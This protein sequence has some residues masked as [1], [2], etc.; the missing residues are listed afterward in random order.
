[1]I[2]AS[3]SSAAV[4]LGFTSM[5]VGKSLMDTSRASLIARLELQLVLIV[6]T[7]F[8]NVKLTLVLSMS[9]QVSGEISGASPDHMMSPAGNVGKRGHPFAYVNHSRMYM[10]TILIC[11]YVPL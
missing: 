4:R 3:L 1:M 8:G 9:A 6:T 5:T 11:I 10:C 7:V 2:L